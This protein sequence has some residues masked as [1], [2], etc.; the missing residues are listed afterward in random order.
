[1]NKRGKLKF[2]ASSASPVSKY[3]N[4]FSSPKR[5][6]EVSSLPMSFVGNIKGGLNVIRAKLLHSSLCSKESSKQCYGFARR[7]VDL[8]GVPSIR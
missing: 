1:M 6:Y 8:G 7:S 5:Q 4:R 3:S 2:T